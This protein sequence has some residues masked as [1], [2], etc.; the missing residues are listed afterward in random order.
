MNFL[1]EFFNLTFDEERDENIYFKLKGKR[2]YIRAYSIA[3]YVVK[4]VQVLAV[5]ASVILLYLFA[6]ILA[7]CLG[8]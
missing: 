2:W 8:F 3:W 6:I 4:T 1:N 5:F 7:D